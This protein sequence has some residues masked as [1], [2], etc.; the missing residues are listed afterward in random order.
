[1]AKKYEDEHELDD[2]L[3]SASDN[4]QDAWKSK[5]EQANKKSIKFIILRDIA[6]VLGGLGLVIFIVWN[7]NNN[8]PVYEGN[9]DLNHVGEGEAGF[10]KEKSE[11][12]ET[13]RALLARR[14]NDDDRFRTMILPR[15]K[16]RLDEMHEADGVVTYEQTLSAFDSQVETELSQ[17]VTDPYQYFV[18]LNKVTWSFPD[19]SCKE[20]KSHYQEILFKKESAAYLYE[21]VVSY[22]KEYHAAIKQGDNICITVTSNRGDNR[23]TLKDVETTLKMDDNKKRNMMSFF[24]NAIYEAHAPS[25]FY[26]D[27]LTT[28]WC[29][30]IYNDEHELINAQFNIPKSD[31]YPNINITQ[32]LWE[33]NSPRG[34]E[35]LTRYE[36]LIE[37]KM[38]LVRQDLG[39]CLSKYEFPRHWMKAKLTF[40]ISPSG[41]FI[42]LVDEESG[43]FDLEDK[44]KS[45]HDAMRC[46]R[47]GK[48]IPVLLNDIPV[49]SKTNS[50]LMVTGDINRPP[51]EV[52]PKIALEKIKWDIKLPSSIKDVSLYKTLIKEKM[53]GVGQELSEC[54]YR[55]GYRKNHITAALTFKVSPSGGPISLILEKPG[56]YHKVETIEV[57]NW[58]SNI[59]IDKLI[60]ECIESGVDTPNFVNDIPVQ[61]T[62]ST[63]LRVTYEIN[64]PDQT[65]T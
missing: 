16:V 57:Y 62:A 20:D 39:A 54:L 40:D 26:T 12:R 4:L 53:E 45:I 61:S 11:A 52:F 51:K 13:C 41:G 21:T 30:S 14:I 2:L 33:H 23:L 60:V 24:N 25:V 28:Q 10:A 47:I 56:S 65:D 37:Q 49:Q 6:I 38:E 1:M 58:G 59:K 35:D 55:K 19:D 15:L 32:T 29:Y 7:L 48:V 27:F 3:M 50:K 42:R 34:I 17:N 22:M 63:E 43:I 18:K 36:S 44:D 5:E 9:H 64:A 8:D 46:L 31:D